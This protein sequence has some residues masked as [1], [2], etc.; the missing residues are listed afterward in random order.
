V[1]GYV[2]AYVGAVDVTL[3]VAGLWITGRRR[4]RTANKET[5]DA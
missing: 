1:N 5:T 4:N 2:L 3:L